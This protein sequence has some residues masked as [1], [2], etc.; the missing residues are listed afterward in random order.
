MLLAE[1][2]RRWNQVPDAPGL[3]P[4]EIRKLLIFALVFAKVAEGQLGDPVGRWYVWN[5]ASSLASCTPAH[6]GLISQSKKQF[7]IAWAAT[8]SSMMCKESYISNSF[9][10]NTRNFWHLPLCL[11]TVFLQAALAL[12]SL[13]MSDLLAWQ[14]KQHSLE[15]APFN[16]YSFWNHSPVIANTRTE[17]IGSQPGLP[18]WNMGAICPHRGP[19][20]VQH[21]AEAAS[22]LTKCGAWC[23]RRHHPCWGS[24]LGLLTEDSRLLVLMTVMESFL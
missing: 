11:V 7:A 21:E 1:L 19:S 4:T 12:K 6:P 13:Y 23:S 22:E 3:E 20:Q 2:H 14:L 18:S 8:P 16:L 15:L 5:K 10:N 24:T 9:P 17:A